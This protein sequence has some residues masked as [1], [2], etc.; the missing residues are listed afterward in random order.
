[1]ALGNLQLMQKPQRA[2][3]LATFDQVVCQLV[4]DLFRWFRLV[5][6]FLSPVL[7]VLRPEMIVVTAQS[8]ENVVK[9]AKVLQHDAG[10][11]AK[12]RGEVGA[13]VACV[14]GS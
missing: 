7:S 10:H 2:I 11:L 1:M 3:Q 14:F 9:P 8:L 6:M 4:R 13:V 5:G 12:V